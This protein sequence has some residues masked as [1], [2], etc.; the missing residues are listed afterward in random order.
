MNEPNQLK[1]LF[2][3]NSK[4]T[5]LN[6]GS[7]GACPKPVFDNY[8]QWQNKIEN[9]PVQFMTKDVYKNLEISRQELGRF[10]NCDKDDIVYFPNPTHAVASIIENIDIKAND[11]VLSTNLEYGSCDRMWFYHS[12]VN[13]YVYKR[14]Q[15]DIPVIDKKSFINNF[16]EAVTDRTRFIFVSQITS[17]TGMI[18]PVKELIIEAKKRNIK[19]IIDGAHVPG[20]IDLNLKELDPDYY[21]GACHKWLCAPK[22]SSFL[23]V[24]SDLQINMQP[25]LK[26]WGWGEEYPEFINTTELKT[27]SRFQNIFQWQGTRDMSA[28]LSVPKAIEFHREHNWPKVIMRSNKLVLLARN[29]I[30]D[31]TGMPKLCPDDFLGQMATLLFPYHDHIKL[32]NILYDKFNIE[33]PTYR[34]DGYVAFRISIQGYNDINDIELLVSALKTLL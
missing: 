1:K 3:I 24:K 14:T 19:S 32:K 34:K 6:H 9:N 5:F 31:L 25:H 33:I 17:G 12:K 30:S 10:I 15:I 16:W 28:F 20:H 26:S 13:N 8:Q 21:V 18:L 2:Q 7:Y 23:Y 4:I 11:E 22:G 27:S 29:M